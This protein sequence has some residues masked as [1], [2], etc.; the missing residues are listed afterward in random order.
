MAGS[1]PQNKCLNKT[2]ETERQRDT[3]GEKDLFLQRSFI[4]LEIFDF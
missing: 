3:A 4:L 1:S 2:E